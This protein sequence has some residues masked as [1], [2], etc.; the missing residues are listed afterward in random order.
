MQQTLDQHS[1]VATRLFPGREVA[2]LALLDREQLLQLALSGGDEHHAEPLANTSISG[3]AFN[4]TPAAEIQEFPPDQSHDQSNTSPDTVVAPSTSSSLSRLH[5]SGDRSVNT[6]DTL[7]QAPE[8]DTAADE[9]TRRRSVIN[10]VSDD[11]NGL[12]FSL[13]KTSS[14]V[15]VSSI[16]A[17]LKAIFKIAPQV[18]T[19]LQNNCPP[20]ALP[21]RA[22]SPSSSPAPSTRSGEDAGQSTLPPPDVAEHYVDSY[23]NSVHAMMPM[24]DEDAFRHT[25]LYDERIDAP[26]LALFNVVLALG[27][28][29]CGTCDSREHLTYAK[30]ARQIL[31]QKSLGSNHLFVLQAHGLLSGY[32]LHWLNRPNEAHA[33]MGATMR[34]ASAV[35]IHRE[36]DASCTGS[37]AVIPPE[38][39]RR[40]WWSLVCL[41]TWASMTTGRPSFGRLGPG[42]TVK[43][44]ILPLSTNNKQYLASLKLLPL[45]HSI[46]FCRIATRIQDLLATK[47]LLSLEELTTEDAELVKWHDELPPILLYV[48][49]ISRRTGALHTNDSSTPNGGNGSSSGQ[50]QAFEDGSCP[51]LL[52]TPRA[53]MHW[54]YLNL[55]ILMHRPYLIAASLCRVPEANLSEQDIYAIRKCRM[56]AGQAITTIDQTCQDSLIAG[57]NAV[58]LMYQA[59]MVPLISLSTLYTSQETTPNGASITK[60]TEPHPKAQAIEW[61][62]QIKTAIRLFDRMSSYSLA[63]TRSKVVIEQMLQACKDMGSAESQTTETRHLP[64]E[65]SGIVGDFQSSSNSFGAG[66][67]DFDFQDPDM[68]FSWDD[69]AWESTSNTFENV[70]FADAYMREFQDAFEM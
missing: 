16:N 60:T 12:S 8:L 61:E 5:A 62:A 45:I 50:P 19:H 69:M 34:I 21:S 13:D 47:P 1:I 46:A 23:F 58:W 56:L 20:T 51:V 57:W 67:L 32:Y 37:R 31:Q 35:G 38:I 17:A 3:S 27:S 64:T 29:A 9:V 48:L 4:P 25:F 36:Y 7:E 55:R 30:R 44:P 41:D 39:R 52:R 14:Y 22:P 28:L 66:I 42:I 24:I 33:M 15:G 6:L 68:G 43:N 59:V 54:W 2:D 65:Q 11:V 70:P 10:A 26:W 18:Q 53:I 40:T 63:A 49:P